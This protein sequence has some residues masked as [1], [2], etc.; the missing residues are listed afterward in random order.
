MG[1]IWDTSVKSVAVGQAV[2]SVEENNVVELFFSMK[3]IVVWE[4]SFVFVV[5]HD[6]AWGVQQ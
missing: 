3:Q 2:F 4:N 6:V 1:H 5:C